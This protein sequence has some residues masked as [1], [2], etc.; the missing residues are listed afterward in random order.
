MITREFTRLQRTIGYPAGREKKYMPAPVTKRAV[1]MW[2]ALLAAA[3][4]ALATCGQKGSLAQS[5]VQ[6]NAT[7][8]IT[9]DGIVYLNVNDSSSL[10]ELYSSLDEAENCDIPSISVD[11]KGTVEVSKTIAVPSGVELRIRGEGYASYGDR[12][13]ARG[14]TSDVIKSNGSV[15]LFFV[16][17]TASLFMSGMTLQNG[18]GGDDGGG[19]I[20]ALRETSIISDNCSWESLSTSGSG[21]AIAVIG[22]SNLTLRGTNIFSSCSSGSRGGAIYIENT[23]L[24]TQGDV[25]FE[26]CTARHKGG[27]M[28]IK[29]TSKL[30]VSEGALVSFS[31]CTA[32]SEGGDNGGGLCSYDSEITIGANAI[33]S[34]ENNSVLAEGDGGGLYSGSTPITISK[35]ANVS[36]V[37]NNAQ[38]GGGGIYIRGVSDGAEAGDE[39]LVTCFTLEEGANAQFLGNSVGG[40]GAGIHISTGCNVVIAGDVYFEQNV[41][42]RAGA[43]YMD[44]AKTVI[45]GRATFINNTAERWGGALMVI[46]S[47]GGLEINGPAIFQNNSAGRSGGAVYLE[48]AY[49]NVTT[50]KNVEVVWER[51]SAGYDGGVIAVD[52]GGVFIRGG[53]ASANSASQR[54]GVLFSTGESFISWTAGRTWGNSAASGGSM[55]ISNSEV[56]ITDVHLVEDRTPSGG[57]IF[58]VG[59]DARVVNTSFVAPAKLM[60]DFALHVDDD[61]VVRLFSCS[62]E[63]W[64]GDKSLIVNEGQLVMDACDFSQ[65]SNTILLSSSEKATIRNAILGDK[66]YASTGYNTATIFGSDT[67][68]CTTLSEPYS[69]FSN[70]REM[71]CVDAD[72]GMGVLCVDYIAAATGEAVSL[73]RGNSSVELISNFVPTSSTSWSPGK[74]TVYYPDL[75][76]KELTLRYIVDSSSGS[77]WSS[78]GEG[79]MESATDAVL[80][81]LQSFNGS[82]GGLPSENGVFNNLSPD[83]FSW[84]AMPSSGVLVKGQELTISLVATPP[85]VRYPQRPSAVY[86][87]NVSATFLVVSRTAEAG[88][89]ATSRVAEIMAAFFYCSAGDYWDGEECVSCV[90]LMSTMTNGKGSL[91][92]DMPGVTL[93]TLPLAAGETM[94]L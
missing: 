58:F 64:S 72:Y 30:N 57:V 46:D 31:D 29:E 92:C 22:T 39:G 68:T 4:V 18:W 6:Q 87:G 62:F 32:G 7:C 53:S 82:N 83:N 75:V 10:D 88:S 14:A 17:E 84:V 61:S 74:S 80:W 69:C 40:Y 43:L 5:S 81:E 37:N 85:P 65:S 27:G 11:W 91:E 51:N 45:S 70:E 94:T 13:S 48:N 38:D 16:N 49:L 79:V 36:F 42:E 12:D 77:E 33:V 15:R 73:S 24:S 2:R 59:A 28:H 90:E 76:E 67:N 41:G 71:D 54:G 20:Y 60:G 52:G 34:F 35:G 55:Y 21:G 26:N 78:E 47:D 50:D 9:S 44:T 23:T 19:G 3:V 93:D 8:P 25:R 56:N 89:T 1:S 86:N 63:M 66:N